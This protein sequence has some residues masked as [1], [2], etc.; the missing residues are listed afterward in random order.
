MI[1]DIL[2]GYKT[3]GEAVFT[4][5]L[6]L[7]PR[8]CEGHESHNGYLKIGGVSMLSVLNKKVSHIEKNEKRNG[9]SKIE[10]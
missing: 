10:S 5:G 9:G 3:V 4:C 6:F 1:L 7:L 2:I 8:K